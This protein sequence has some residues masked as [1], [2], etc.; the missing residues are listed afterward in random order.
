[1]ENTT[2]FIPTINVL[3]ENSLD[4]RLHLNIDFQNNDLYILQE[5]T[6]S[7]A[8]INYIHNSSK[9]VLSHS[10]AKLNNVFDMFL[11]IQDPM[12]I[13]LDNFEHFF[14]MYM[15]S[16][17]G[18]N[19]FKLY[20]KEC[21][22]SPVAYPVSVFAEGMCIFMQYNPQELRA[23]IYNIMTMFYYYTGQNFYEMIQPRTENIPRPNNV[24]EYTDVA[25]TNTS[26]KKTASTAQQTQKRKSRQE[27]L[28]ALN[29]RNYNVVKPYLGGTS[30]DPGMADTF[31]TNAHFEKCILTNNFYPERQYDE[32]LVGQRSSKP[33][34]AITTRDENS[35]QNVVPGSVCRKNG[36][37]KDSQI[38][39][40]SEHLHRYRQREVLTTSQMD[41]GD[42]GSD[43]R[44][45]HVYVQT[46]FSKIW[47]S[48]NRRH[49]VTLN[50]IYSVMNICVQKITYTL[51]ETKDKQFI[52]S[53]NNCDKIFTCIQNPNTMSTTTTTSAK[54]DDNMLD[55]STTSKRNL[56]TTIKPKKPTIEVTFNRD[57]FSKKRTTNERLKFR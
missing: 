11:Q 21:E 36:M 6:R 22:K 39:Q 1:M 51:L 52:E 44:H 30:S 9:T 15:H 13:F 2:L 55:D 26:T 46:N 31:L 12:A 24:D 18:K 32:V 16:K 56:P 27:K 3:Q 5:L 17:Y 7:A 29:R 35:T 50:I 53:T 54:N 43:G 10:K 48:I 49:L 47:S 23:Y 42:G 19:N 38:F 20:M 8:L 37:S 14:A 33:V 45:K 41:A 34:V 4:Q 57:T 40:L 25:P 28:C